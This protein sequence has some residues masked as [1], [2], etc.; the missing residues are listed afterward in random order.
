MSG[1]KL[2]SVVDDDPSIRDSTKTLLRS[3][4]YPV[5]TFDSAE[6]FLDSGALAETDCLILDIRM[7]GIDGLE[8]QRRLNDIHSRV[9]IIFVT[10]HDDRANR[11]QALEAGA[12]GFLCKPF[13]ANVLITTVQAA[14]G[15]PH[16][17]HPMSGP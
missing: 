14:L 16:M 5:T 17:E 12:V 11:R 1:R 15:G 7:P 3:V 10:A 9:P 8:L 4:G 2:I 6:S 13:E